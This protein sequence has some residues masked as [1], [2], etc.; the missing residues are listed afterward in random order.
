MVLSTFKSPRKLAPDLSPEGKTFDKNSKTSPQ[1]SASDDFAARLMSSLPILST[2]RPGP[3]EDERSY[4]QINHR[5]NSKLYTLKCR[6]MR[7]E[8]KAKALLNT[9]LGLISMKSSNRIKGV[10]ESKRS[11][12]WI[13]TLTEANTID[14]LFCH[15][16]SYIN[17]DKCLFTILRRRDIQE[18]ISKSH[19]SGQSQNIGMPIQVWEDLIQ[20]IG[21][22]QLCRWFLNKK[23]DFILNSV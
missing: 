23:R 13:S 6:G 9:Q 4:K 8:K 2:I 15:S 7:L 21:F 11:N 3:F 17:Q 10:D 16:Q 5:R 22:V 18:K 20:W 1:N 14:T 12:S 19:F